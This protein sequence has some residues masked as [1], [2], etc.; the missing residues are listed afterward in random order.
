MF[1]G[2]QRKRLAIDVGAVLCSGPKTRMTGIYR[3]T[4]EFIKALAS[5]ESPGFDIVLF[6]QRLRRPTLRSL[7]L[8]FP[9]RQIRLPRWDSI[10][11][12]KTWFP[13]VEAI[14]YHDLFHA[15][16]NFVYLKRPENV[17]ATIHDAMFF[18]HPEAELGH[19][20]EAKLIGPFARRCRGI[21]TC[22][23]ASK[24]DILT[25]LEVD[26]ARV[27]VLPWGVRHDVF[28]PEDDDESLRTFL[29]ARFGL[30]RPYFLQV[31]CSSGRKNSRLVFEQYRR[32]F[33]GKPD[34]DMVF[35]WHAPPPDVLTLCEREGLQDHVHFVS[36]LTDE[37]L[38]LLY[39]GATAHLFP[40]AYEGF[41]LPVLEAMACGTPSVTSCSS[42]LPEV[43]GDAALYV[44]LADPDELFK[45]MERF[46]NHRYD[47]AELRAKGLERA[48]QFRWDGYVRGVL[49][50]YE[51]YL[52]DI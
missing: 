37:E 24:T 31:S 22:S 1:K 19:E 40:S 51:Y 17:L 15:T 12:V 14:C 26:P 30:R 4:L 29:K 25:F 9:S 21:I 32:L 10:E 36:C 39:C 41:G 48:Q 18:A 27:H 7:N 20:R 13:L 3:T 35:V 49:K 38:R 2:V 28:H 50:L 45:I 11:R 43:G 23:E 6:G 8:G 47:R 33:R 16:A 42:S 44:N 46:E 5:A 34:N 52:T